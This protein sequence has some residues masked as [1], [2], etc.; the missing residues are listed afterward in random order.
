LLR[1]W[2]VTE[3]NYAAYQ[4]A[5]GGGDSKLAQT[6]QL[7]EHMQKSGCVPR[8]PE[9]ATK[10]FRHHNTIDWKFHTGAVVESPSDIN[11]ELVRC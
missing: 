1:A 8:K 2:R 4:G 10:N 3:G 5:S 11:T 9:D 6:Q 7:A